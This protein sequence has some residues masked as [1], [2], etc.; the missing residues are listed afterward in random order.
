MPVHRA[1]IL[2]RL[3]M[4]LGATTASCVAPEPADV[5]AVDAPALYAER[6]AA[7]HGFDGAGTD[8]GPDLPSRV[9]GLDAEEVADVVLFG[10]GLMP[11]VDVDEVEAQA[12]AEFVLDAVVP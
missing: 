12:L 4:V 5:A 8:A 11:A 6:C 9:A 2:L 3:L 1:L 7:C 10:V